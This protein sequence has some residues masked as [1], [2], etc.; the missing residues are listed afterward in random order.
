MRLKRGCGYAK[1]LSLLRLRLTADGRLRSR[2]TCS[3]PFTGF[4][5]FLAAA[6]ARD[7]F[8]CGYAVAKATPKSRH[9]VP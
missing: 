1:L 6:L 2:L 3:P 5:Y 8:T 7:S 4:G 9:F